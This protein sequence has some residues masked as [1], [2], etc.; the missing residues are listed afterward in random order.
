MVSF[1]LK[2]LKLKFSEFQ[3]CDEVGSSASI[4]DTILL[5]NP[6]FF[7]SR[8]H[9]LYTIKVHIFSQN[10]DTLKTSEFL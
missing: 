6:L 10:F 5:C 2:F 1:I 4:Y 8:Q 3:C 9:E 7:S